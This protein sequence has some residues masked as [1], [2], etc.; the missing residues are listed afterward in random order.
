RRLRRGE[1]RMNGF[2]A[3]GA[4]ARS[5]PPDPAKRVNF[6]QGLVLGVDE[7][8][9][10]SAYLAN[11]A[12]SLARDLLGY[13]TVTGLRVSRET[14]ANGAAIVVGDGI[15]LS[16]R[17]RPIR[18]T[19]PQTLALNEWLDARRR[20]LVFHLVP[21]GGSPP[22]DLLKLFVV[23]CYQQCATDNQPGPGE[24]CRTDDPPQI[25]TRIADDFRL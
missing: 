4:G 3:G 2:T 25:Y 18:V 6:M 22:G 19:M 7:L 5:V 17:G 24:P 21:G 14:R 8:T 1:T 13:G 16:P 9:Q 11:R 12:E 23:L 15:A 10:E 20:E